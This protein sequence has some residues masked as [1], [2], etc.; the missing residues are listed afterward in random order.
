MGFIRRN[1]GGSHNKA[2]I[3]VDADEQTRCHHLA[4][5]I[6]DAHLLVRKCVVG[7]EF[8]NERR[9]TVAAPGVVTALEGAEHLAFFMRIGDCPQYA[10]AGE[11]LG[12]WVRQYAYAGEN[13]GLWVRSRESWLM[14][15]E[16][17]GLWVRMLP[18][19]LRKRA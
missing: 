4:V 9:E 8:V 2:A 17:S 11:N 5:A 13:L 12:L 6:D 10:Y 14:A 1:G 18:R 15:G 16:N 7:V 19:D 3:L